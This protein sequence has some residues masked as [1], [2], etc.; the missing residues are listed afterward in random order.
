VPL[1]VDRRCGPPPPLT[2]D[3]WV[4]VDDVDPPPLTSDLWVWVDDV[5][6]LLIETFELG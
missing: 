6:P 2:S 4:W 3:L 1:G 5:E